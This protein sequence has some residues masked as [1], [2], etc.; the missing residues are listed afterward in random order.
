MDVPTALIALQTCDLEIRRAAKLLDELPEKRSILETRHKAEEV[1]QL[2][3][4]A[5]EL[6]HRLERAIAANTDEVSALDEKIAGV[7]KTLDGGQVTKPKEVHN[8]SREMDALKR[9]EDKLDN[10]T[11][12]LMERLEKAREQVAKVDT[13]LQRLSTRESELIAAYRLKGGEVQSD[14]E[15][16]KQQRAELAAAVGDEL[17]ARYEAAAAAKGGIGAARLLEVA[18]SACRVELPSE[19]LRELREGADVGVCPNCRRLLVVRGD[20]ASE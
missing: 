11:L 3:G 20:D 6:V 7:Q 18:C 5:E 15:A 10:D 4:K 9:R 2:K 14:L 13:A 19:R 12:S 17:L 8:L 16:H 1:R